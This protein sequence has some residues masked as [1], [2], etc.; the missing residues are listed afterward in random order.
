MGNDRN[1]NKRQQQWKTCSLCARCLCLLQIPLRSCLNMSQSFPP[2][3]FIWCNDGRQGGPT[4]RPAARRG[5]HACCND[6]DFCNRQLRPVIKYYALS[7]ATPG[8][9]P[10]SVSLAPSVIYEGALCC[11]RV[12]R[13]FHNPAP[14][15]PAQFPFHIHNRSSNCKENAR[16]SSCFVPICLFF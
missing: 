3:R 15:R 9:G 6:R 5:G 2:G 13:L 12:K 1:N 8:G 4:A 11:A 14:P 16:R 10:E 7:T